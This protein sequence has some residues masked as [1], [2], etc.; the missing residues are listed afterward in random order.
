MGASVVVVAGTTLAEAVWMMDALDLGGADPSIARAVSMGQVSVD[1]LLV[2]AVIVTPSLA[3]ASVGVLGENKAIAARRLLDSL[4][5]SLAKTGLGSRVRATS[6]HA[7]IVQDKLFGDGFYSLPFPSAEAVE[8]EFASKGR[9]VETRFE[10]GDMDRPYSRKVTEHFEA[11]AQKPAVG[12]LVVDRAGPYSH[13][14]VNTVAGYKPVP[15]LEPYLE[16]VARG[17]RNAR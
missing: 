2:S 8:P 16:A 15:T 6:L 9:T 3:L 1:G 10:D 13:V 17:M 11:V 5:R 4:R 12:E 7:Q 14:T